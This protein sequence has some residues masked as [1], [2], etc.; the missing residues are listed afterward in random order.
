[1]HIEPTESLGRRLKE[2]KK[3]GR[4]EKRKGGRKEGTEE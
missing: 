2:E 3:K 1:V 4:K